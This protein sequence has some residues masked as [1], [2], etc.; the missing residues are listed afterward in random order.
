MKNTILWV[1]RLIPAI[2]L[3]QTL[4]FKF[5]AQPE[6]VALFSKLGVE[7]WGRI[8]AGI[9]EL[10]AA[11]LLVVPKFSKYGAALA[12]ATMCGAIGAHLLVLGVQSNNDGGY[13]FVLAFI[14]LLTA[15]TVLFIE[16]KENEYSVKKLF[17]A[18]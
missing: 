2:I 4:F 5:T 18:K 13:L 11:I 12:I 17:F 3:L 8:I 1:C 7:P 15:A 14:V 6:S 16:L 10:C 9:M